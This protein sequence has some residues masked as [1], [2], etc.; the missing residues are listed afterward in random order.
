MS[1]WRRMYERWTL[2]VRRCWAEVLAS[3]GFVTSREH[4]SSIFEFFRLETIYFALR[5]LSIIYLLQCTAVRCGVSEQGDESIRYAAVCP[6]QL[7]SNERVSASASPKCAALLSNCPFFS[8]CVYSSVHSSVAVSAVC[9]TWTHKISSWQWPGPS[10][11]SWSH[12]PH[13][14]YQHCRHSQCV[15]I[16][17]CNYSFEVFSHTISI[18]RNKLRSSVCIRL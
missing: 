2:A 9:W 7:H 5:R 17:N 6:L 12:S 16:L 15:S 8:P 13:P 10:P 4:F 3:N 11:V 1:V 14:T 18:T